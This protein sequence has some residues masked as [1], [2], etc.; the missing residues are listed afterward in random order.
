MQKANTVGTASQ[1]KK[2]DSTYG[3]G[4][5]GVAVELMP[6]P[7]DRTGYTSAVGGQV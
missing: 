3:K 7:N 2:Y 4:S 1:D 5:D 6:T